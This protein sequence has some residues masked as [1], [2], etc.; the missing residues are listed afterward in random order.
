MNLRETIRKYQST[1][2]LLLFAFV[3]FHFMTKY[4]TREA[5]LESLT[6][7][8]SELDVSSFLDI[9]QS[10][11]TT[12]IDTEF[13]TDFNNAR[14]REYK[15]NVPP[16]SSSG[17]G[18]SNPFIDGSDSFINP[19]QQTPNITPT[20]VPEPIV[21]EVIEEPSEEEVVEETPSEETTEG[22]E[23]VTEETEEDE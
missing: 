11:D 23:E 4:L 8:G 20:P 21:E 16:V 2:L 3:A 22:V 12:A 14:F 5:D 10:L 17:Y 6:D 7:T 13:V 1:I 9:I 18:R 15:V 19:V